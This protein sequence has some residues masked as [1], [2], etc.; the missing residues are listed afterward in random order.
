MYL[1]LFLVHLATLLLG[2][3]LILTG[4]LLT[5]VSTFAIHIS[6]AAL[7]HALT[8]HGITI[9]PSPLSATTCLGIERGE[10]KQNEEQ[11]E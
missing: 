5:L 11:A 10:S 6:G 9:A 4:I 2:A 7:P 3:I 8:L 1:V